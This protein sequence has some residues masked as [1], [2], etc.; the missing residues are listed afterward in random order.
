MGQRNIEKS[1]EFSVKVTQTSEIVNELSI[2]YLYTQRDAIQASLDD[3][4]ELISL[5]EG[6]GAVSESAA[7][8][9]KAASLK[10]S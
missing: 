7:I 4:N 3:V 1:G 8:A 10:V 9:M 5:A 2:D 6:V